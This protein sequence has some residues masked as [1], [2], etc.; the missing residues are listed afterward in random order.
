M[1]RQKLFYRVRWSERL[2][3]L[4]TQAYQSILP[5]NGDINQENEIESGETDF[6]MVVIHNCHLI[7]LKEMNV[8][9][10]VHTLHTHFIVS[11]RRAAYKGLLKLFR[12]A[13]VTLSKTRDAGGRV[14]LETAHNCVTVKNGRDIA[15]LLVRPLIPSHQ[16]YCKHALRS[17]RKK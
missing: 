4:K 10:Y 6:I 1:P 17:K 15:L 8:R 11:Q 13:F 5:M 2:Q 9:T 16:Q 7:K 3:I 14:F 12:R